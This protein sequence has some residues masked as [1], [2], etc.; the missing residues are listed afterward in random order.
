MIIA[1]D[2][3]GVRYFRMARAAFG[4]AL[5]WDLYRRVTWG[6]PGPVA[7]ALEGAFRARA[8]DE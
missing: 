7:A 5:Y 4:R 3:G 2:H 1:S 6:S 8:A